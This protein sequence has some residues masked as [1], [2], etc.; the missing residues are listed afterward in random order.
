MPKSTPADQL[1]PPS[2][3]DR[4]DIYRTITDK[5]IAAIE[6]NPGEPVM[7]WHRGGFR[8]VI[9]TNAAT[10]NEYCGVNILSLWISLDDETLVARDSTGNRT[11]AIF[12][13]LSV[14]S[15]R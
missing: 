15:H 8:Q 2:E 5:I 6:Q 11:A 3:S 12:A 1:K 7:P 9:P 4:R 14:V 10:G 13:R